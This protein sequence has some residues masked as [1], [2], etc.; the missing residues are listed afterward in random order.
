MTTLNRPAAAARGLFARWRAANRR[1]R[2]HRV[3]RNLPDYLL[4]DMG[5]EREI[6]P[7]IPGWT[8]AH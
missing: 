5:L 7:R 1:E 3:L 6:V 2:D 4:R 8:Q